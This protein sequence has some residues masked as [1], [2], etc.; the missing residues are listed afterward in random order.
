MTIEVTPKQNEYLTK[1][2]KEPKTSKDFGVTKDAAA[3]MLSKLKKAGLV[4]SERMKGKTI[5]EYRLVKPYQELVED[6][7]RII[8]RGEGM[9]VPDEEI[10][11]AAILRNAGMTGRGLKDQY[12]KLYPNRTKS[13][14]THIVGKAR[15]RR[16]CR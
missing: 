13:G 14:V 8:S 3:K 5:F 6:G 4:K 9:K 16:L 12:H 11:Y 15:K 10:F 2:D 1:L 7:L